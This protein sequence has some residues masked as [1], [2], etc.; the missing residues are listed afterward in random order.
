MAGERGPARKESV[1][2]GLPG[3]ALT[4]REEGDAMEDIGGRIRLP[5][6]VKY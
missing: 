6:G 3:P 1:Q 2:P 5:P 4:R